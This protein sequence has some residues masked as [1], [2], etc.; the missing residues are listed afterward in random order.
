MGESV[1]ENDES[2]T[3][4][5]YRACDKGEFIIYPVCACWDNEGFV[6]STSYSFSYNTFFISNPSRYNFKV[7]S[8]IVAVNTNVLNTWIDTS[9]FTKPTRPFATQFATWFATRACSV[10]PCVC[11][12]SR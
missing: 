3:R 11:T 10:S 12:C 5:G 8:R 1:K 4:P 7:T 2:I 6:T 9:S